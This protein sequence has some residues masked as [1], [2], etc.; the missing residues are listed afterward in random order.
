MLP[1]AQVSA[2]THVSRFQ[3]HSSGGDLPGS[4]GNRL[5]IPESESWSFDLD[6]SGSGFGHRI[7]LQG[8]VV[9]SGPVDFH[10][11][12]AESFLSP[13]RFG[14]APVLA[15]EDDGIF[16]LR[17][18]GDSWRSV[19]ASAAHVFEPVR[20]GF[21]ELCEHLGVFIGDVVFLVWVLGDF[22]ELEVFAV[23][24]AS[25]A[26]WLDEPP[27]GRADGKS[28]KFLGFIA[29]M[30]LEKDR[31]VGGFLFRIL[32]VRQEV[33]SVEFVFGFVWL[34]DVASGQECRHNIDVSTKT[35]GF[36]VLW[37]V[38][39]PAD[40]TRNSR[41]AFVDATFPGEH[42]AVVAVTLGAVVGQ[43]NHDGVLGNPEFGEFRHEATKIVVDVGHHAVNF[44]E[45]VLFGFAPEW[46]TDFRKR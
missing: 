34:T 39:G 40:E 24:T 19:P 28:S 13:G 44:G 4:G 43:E 37:E 42:A 46:L 23:L 31:A 32:Q 22:V 26:V 7:E 1:T 38:S 15:S 36:L 10:F 35:S 29:T 12:M 21:L 14:T 17:S 6:R 18:D 16:V 3:L 2:E 45:V 9:F 20:V 8:D 5:S 27:V 33:D 41:A 30:P 25:D 11:P